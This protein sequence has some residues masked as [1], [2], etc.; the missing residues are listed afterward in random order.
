MSDRIRVPGYT[1]KKDFGNGI[2]IRPF[3]PSLVGLQLT[4]NTGTPI[5]TLG[6]FNITTNT[7]H[8][9][10]KIFKTDKFSKK[11][12]FDD[13][14]E[15]SIYQTSVRLT[16]NPSKLTNFVL[17]APLA[18]FIRV[19]LEE[20]ITK[21]PAALYITPNYGD[22]YSGKTMENVIYD[23]YTNTTTF[24]TNLEAIENNFEINI[25]ESLVP[26][27]LYQSNPNKN[28]Y[29]NY[30]N[31]R[32]IY[33]DKFFNLISY[34]NN[35]EGYLE[36][37]VSGQLVV[38]NY[39]RNIYIAPQEK[40]LDY[41]FNNLSIL[42]KHLLNRTSTPVYTA[43]F[44]LVIKPDTGGIVY[45]NKSVTWPLSDGYNIDFNTS[46]YI[47]Y[48][49]SLLNICNEL[50]KSQTNLIS[51]FLVTE[52]I[53]SFDTTSNDELTDLDVDQQRVNKVLTLYGLQFDKLNTYIN[54][55]KFANTVSY[56]KHDNVPDIYLKNLAKTLGWD[57][58]LFNFNDT[59]SNETWRKLI[60]NT[61]WIWKSKGTRKSVEFVLKLIGI[62]NGLIK[63]EE[64]VYR[65]N[66]KIDTNILT[67]VLINNNQAT[68]LDNYSVDINGN[69][70]PQKNT[71][72]LYFQSD[73]RWYR[74]TGGSNAVIDITTGNNPHIGNYDDGNKF[75]NQFR[76]LIPNFVS[77]IVSSTT[78]T[79]TTEQ[80][81]T[82]YKLGTFNDN[83]DTLYVDSFSDDF[84]DFS[85]CFVV[86]NTIL[87]KENIKDTCLIE[88]NNVLN[89]KIDKKLPDNNCKLNIVDTQY[90]SQFNYLK[91]Y[92]K[93][94][95]IDGGIYNE[96]VINKFVNINCCN[97]NNN[98]PYFFNEMS[99]NQS[100]GYELINSGYICCKATNKC[101]CLTTC[102]WVL[103]DEKIMDIDGETYLVFKTELNE[104]RVTSID[105]CNCPQ[106]YTTPS[107][108]KDPFTEET[109][110]GCRITSLDNIKLSNIAA[111]FENRA[112]SNYT[113]CG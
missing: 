110:F 104:K 89:V 68:N 77:T 75:L 51:R 10:D 84:M 73:G 28:L 63:F 2:E 8:K 13:S 102:N 81:F 25:L 3:S 21:W 74:E 49:T 112:N 107:I 41:F 33:D 5:F 19:E 64:H 76:G 78:Q 40:Y 67:K 9:V 82:N 103:A 62:P 50:D 72:N 29:E 88:E 61:P 71:P 55:I 97:S 96:V 16:A 14:N 93:L 6:N 79:I 46:E 66:N 98:V 23:E 90:D 44:D 59:E 106:T 32:L 1:Q 18:E 42:G 39:Y 70:K 52:S 87:G 113:N 109:G 37:V 53:S 11:K 100:I 99:G 38:T 24:N 56:N 45:T 36:F 12:I 111:I 85:N 15:T 94:L 69:P 30:I 22:T 92:H 95:G 65:A 80:L 43:S 47:N 83:T 35:T 91:F 17:F 58:N 4:D 7:E 105:G 60:L 57:V 31:Y 101:G 20:I 108:V 86:D 34:N 27:N 26:N 48:A 54:G